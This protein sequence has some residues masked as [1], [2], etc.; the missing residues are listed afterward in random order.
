M[1]KSINQKLND[2]LNEIDNSKDEIDKVNSDNSVNNEIKDQIDSEIN[3]IDNEIKNET[4]P[5]ET[6]KTSEEISSEFNQFPELIESNFLN[7]ELDYCKNEEIDEQQ[8]NIDK[9]KVQNHP[10]FKLLRKLN[11]EIFGRFL[12]TRI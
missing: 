1:E 11:F 9:Q 7:E 8:L 12:V 4:D 2:K 3:K 6:I 5:N 10:L